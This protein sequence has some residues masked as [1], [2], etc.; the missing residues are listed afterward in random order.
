M[1][2]VP[3][4][5][6][7]H[8]ALT[9][10]WRGRDAIVAVAVAI[11]ESSGNLNANK[12]LK[13]TDGT[14]KSDARGLWQINVTA[15]P[16]Y[17]SHNLYDGQTNAN[18]AYA[19]WKQSGWGPW[20]AHK[21]G[22]YIM[23]LPEATVAVGVAAPAAPVYNAA[24][25]VGSTGNVISDAGRLLVWLEQ[26]R[27]WVRIAKAVVGGALILVALNMVMKPVVAPVVQPIVSAGKKV[28]KVAAV[29][30]K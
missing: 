4:A 9:A 14:V 26:P 2:I 25:A 20:S 17:A 5:T 13:K 7:A 15:H 29:I 10:G 21:S 8:Y 6:I 28:A 1:T 19:I 22:A 11:S 16:E 23:N 3:S 27:T 30:P 12:V 24:E 18:D